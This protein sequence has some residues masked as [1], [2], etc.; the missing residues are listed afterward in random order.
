MEDEF[1]DELVS[2]RAELNAEK[3]G[4]LRLRPA[5]S[6]TG[7]LDRAVDL[8]VKYASRRMPD[9]EFKQYNG[10]V[11][12]VI[13]SYE[14]DRKLGEIEADY[15][16]L[17]A[18]D[19]RDVCPYAEGSPYSWVQ[20]TLAMLSSDPVFA[21]RNAPGFQERL[22]R[23]GRIVARAVDMGTKH[24]KAILAGYAQTFRQ[25]DVTQNKKVLERQLREYRTTVTTGGGATASASG[26]GA[27][28]FAPP[29]FLLDQWA[30]YRSP[31]STFVGQLDDSTALPEF[32]M[33]VYVPSVSTGAAAGEDTEGNT[34]TTGSPV[35]TY[36]S[37]A[38]EQFAGQVITS[39]AVLDRCGPGI[40]GDVWLFQQVKNQLMAPVD[41]Y[42]I[43]QATANAATVTNNGSF[44]LAT[45]SGAGGFIG[46]LKHCKSKLTDQAGT[47]LRGTHCF[48][49]DN[50]IDYL[51]ALADA[52]GRPLI[53]PAF[54]D[55]RLPI[56]S[57]GDPIAEGYSGY[58]LNGLALFGDS[59]IPTTTTANL[60]QIVVCRADAIL[61]LQSPVAMFVRPQ[62]QAGNLEPTVGA[63]VYATTIPR[64]NSAVAVLGG[65]AYAA[66]T[67]Q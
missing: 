29:A 62:F 56:K 54:D 25:Q 48:A 16:S 65:G 37:G 10:L 14:R 34:T 6:A 7:H 58:V 9:D 27:A 1:V 30:V 53:V 64:W 33:Q 38:V 60:N 11:D 49:V 67:F 52:Q 35:T 13:R 20:D 31:A 46:D 23:H 12:T 40:G 50:F 44:S 24:G 51:G 32:G 26:G 19:Q 15:R 63:Y 21:D 41:V 18:S 61:H 36:L 43:T 2:D 17:V 42:A 28:A 8:Q 57:V 4:L 45:A 22:S 66:S 55:N 39:Q 3:I 5:T 59:N 47:R